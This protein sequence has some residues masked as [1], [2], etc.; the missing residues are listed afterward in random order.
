MI[1]SSNP[2]RA[3]SPCGVRAKNHMKKGGIE[4]YYLT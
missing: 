3:L 1:F 4:K 2:A